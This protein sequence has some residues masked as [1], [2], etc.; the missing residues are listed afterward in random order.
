VFDIAALRVLLLVVTGWLE[1]RERDAIGY[2]RI[3]CCAGN[4]M[5]GAFDALLRVS[6]QTRAEHLLNHGAIPSPPI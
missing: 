6:G 2:L 5:A 3:A 1:C 4:W